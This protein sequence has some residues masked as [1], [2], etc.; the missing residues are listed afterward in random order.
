MEKYMNVLVAIVLGLLVLVAL[1]LVV[2]YIGGDL[3]SPIC[4]SFCNPIADSVQKILPDFAGFA[5]NVAEWCN[6]CGS[7]SAG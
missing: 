7:C 5:V 3:M 4:C 2:S 1:M 6:I